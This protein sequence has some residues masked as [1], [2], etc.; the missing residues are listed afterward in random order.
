MIELYKNAYES[1]S[2]DL[3]S[4]NKWLKTLCGVKFVAKNNLVIKIIAA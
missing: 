2:S 4:I 3:K 1:G